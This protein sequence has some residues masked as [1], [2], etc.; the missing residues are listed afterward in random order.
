MLNK[1]LRKQTIDTLYAM[2]VFI[3][4]LHEQL[5]ELGAKSRISS[6]TTLYR[7]Q[8]MANHEFE[9]LQTNR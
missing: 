9:E 1:A 5:D 4:H 3:R 8:A 2:R 7:G 6:K